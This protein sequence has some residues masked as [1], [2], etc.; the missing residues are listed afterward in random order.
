LARAEA[1]KPWLEKVKEISDGH[2][3][4]IPWLEDASIENILKT[5]ALA[6]KADS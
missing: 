3:V 4:V 6:E 5:A 1:E 2:F